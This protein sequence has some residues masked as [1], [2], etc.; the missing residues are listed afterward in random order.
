MAIFNRE[1]V[2]D[3]ELTG[4]DITDGDRVIELGLVEVFTIANIGFIGRKRQWQFNPE[5]RISPPEVQKIHKLSPEY[6]EKQPKFSDSVQ[7]ILS[8]IGNASLVHHCWVNPDGV[9]SKDEEALNAEFT[10]AGLPIIDHARWVNLKPW[11]VTKSPEKN[12]L[13]H[14]LDLYGVDRSAREARHGAL[15]D[16]ELTAK[17]YLKIKNEL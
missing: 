16:A 1:L 6:L 13:N 2:L 11:A 3:T 7:D 10:R 15:I 8:F 14:M 17:Y 12:S 4:L 9:H 5:G